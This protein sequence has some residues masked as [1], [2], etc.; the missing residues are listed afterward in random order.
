MRVTVKIANDKLDCESKPFS[1]EIEAKGWALYMCKAYGMEI[2]DNDE[3][4]DNLGAYGVTI[5]E[6]DAPR[7]GDTVEATEGAE[8][9][10]DGGE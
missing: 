7:A 9:E 6:S 3:F 10:A 1:T 8:A 5:E 2:N 4:L